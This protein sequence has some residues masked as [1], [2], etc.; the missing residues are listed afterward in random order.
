MV[1]ELKVVVCGDSGTGKTSLTSHFALGTAPPSPASTVGASFLQKR[2]QTSAESEVC[3]QLWDTA[4]QERFRAMA[5]MYYR[6][7]KGAVIVVDCSVAE[8][9]PSIPSIPSIQIEILSS[10]G[11]FCYT[12]R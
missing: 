5:P 10:L 1:V 2:L 3:L 7:A 4:G 9:R 12:T 6:N 8:V 11:S